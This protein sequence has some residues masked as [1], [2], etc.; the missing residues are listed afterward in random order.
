MATPQ[1]YTSMPWAP[2]SNIAQEDDSPTPLR[3]ATPNTEALIEQLAA[4]HA[5]QRQQE[6]RIR[7]LLSKQ[8]D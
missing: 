3:T 7:E 5:L 8:H 4:S 2:R 1:D 6:S